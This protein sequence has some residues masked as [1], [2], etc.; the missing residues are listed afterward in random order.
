MDN[1]EGD[2]VN[3]F[4]ESFIENLSGSHKTVKFIIYDYGTER[5]FS[6]IVLKIYLGITRVMSWSLS[7]RTGFQL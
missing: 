4:E 5:L 7:P 1:F 2:F 6:L 3:D